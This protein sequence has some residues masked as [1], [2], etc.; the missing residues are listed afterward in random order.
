MTERF[1]RFKKNFNYV[2][3]EKKG[4]GKDVTKN[5]NKNMKL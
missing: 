3:S 1:K 5:M 4:L 2:D